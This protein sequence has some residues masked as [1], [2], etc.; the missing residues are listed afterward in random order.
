MK[1]FVFA[2]TLIVL[3][4]SANAQSFSCRIGTQPSC[5]A[6]GDTV[7]SSLGRC[8]SDN[9]VCFDRYQCNFEG[10]TCA[11][12]VTECV[13]DFNDLLQTHNRL[14]G[15]YNDLLEDRDGLLRDRDDLLDTGRALARD[16]DDLRACLQ[17]AST[18]E[19]ARNCGWQ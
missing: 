19:S 7:C 4:S 10:F 1:R 17:F 3:G 18:L 8:V 12:E 2:A 14:V 9:A 13:D 15:D 6:Y 11:S 5:L 16:L